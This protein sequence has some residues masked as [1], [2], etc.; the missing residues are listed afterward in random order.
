MQATKL[1]SAAQID[2][3]E[4]GS[5]IYQDVLSCLDKHRIDGITL[6]PYRSKQLRAMSYQSRIE[7]CS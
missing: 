1:F 5:K 4:G 3:E 7:N 6:L 2:E